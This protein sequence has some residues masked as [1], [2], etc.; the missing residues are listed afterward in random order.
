MRINKYIAF[1][2]VLLFLSACATYKVQYKDTVTKASFP[3]NKEIELFTKLID[4]TPPQAD[5][6][7]KRGKAHYDVGD[8]QNAFKDYEKAASMDPKPEYIKKRNF[9][10]IRKARSVCMSSNHHLI[11]I[12]LYP[13][14]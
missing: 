9:I 11:V 10:F 5:L 4:Q 3:I 12:I 1:V 14:F 8:L 7:F 13:F 2:P 6:Y